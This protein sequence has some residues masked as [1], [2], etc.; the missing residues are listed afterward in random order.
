VISDR[1]LNFLKE[2]KKLFKVFVQLGDVE[3]K[4]VLNFAKRVLMGQIEYGKF[5]EKK[6]D[7][8]DFLKELHFEMLDSFVYMERELLKK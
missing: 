1:G 7:K 4:I 8:R 5:K 2:N 3:R 6:L